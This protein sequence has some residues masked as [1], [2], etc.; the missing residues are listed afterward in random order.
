MHQEL[1]LVKGVQKAIGDTQSAEQGVTSINLMDTGAGFALNPADG[2]QPNLPGL[3]AGGVWADS[4][5]ADGRLLVSGADGNVTETINLTIATGDSVTLFKALSKLHRFI[6]DCREMWTTFSQIE[7]VFLQWWAFGAPGRQYALIYN[8]DIAVEYP[9]VEQGAIADV[10]LSIE[11]EPYWRGLAP[12]ANPKVWTFEFRK[13]SFTSSDLGLVTGTTDHLVYDATV[14]NETTWADNTAPTTNNYVDIAASLVPGDA[15][16]LVEMAVSATPTAASYNVTDIYVSRCTKPLTYPDRI[17]S[18]TVYRRNTLNANDASPGTDTTLAADAGGAEGGRAQITF[19]T[20]ATNAERLEWNSNQDVGYTNWAG[21]Y[22]VFVRARQNGGSANQIL[23]QLYRSGGVGVDD[24]PVTEQ[25]YA[26]LR[27][28]AGATDAWP[29]SYLG[30]VTIPPQERVNVSPDGTGLAVNSNSAFAFYLY[31]ERTTGAGVLY[32]SDLIFVPV[33]E[34][35]A[36]MRDSVRIASSS[37]IAVCDN[38]G[39]FAH[40][41]INPIALVNATSPGIVDRYIELR[42]QD[43]T[44]KPG[45]TNRLYFLNSGEISGSA[46]CDV[47]CTLTVR[48]NII[49]RWRGV[50]DS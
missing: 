48:L 7:P 49:P 3:K 13:Q 42:G 2:W 36:L 45:V 4:T 28:G 29:L 10:T 26:E 33:D 35:C 8:I 43:I 14:H 1:F 32:V 18:D 37:R 31:A 16:A 34:Q 25:V 41:D 20:V 44:L 38:T 50:R 17:D 27:A 24:I 22:A 46:V 19:A 30:E 11:R 40:G 47:D 39:Y 6:A 21:R 5:V 15:E 12:G 9:D 23:M